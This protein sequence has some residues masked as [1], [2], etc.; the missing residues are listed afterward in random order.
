MINKQA[1]EHS[2]PSPRGGFGVGVSIFLF[3][4]I[5]VAAACSDEEEDYDPYYSWGSRNAQWFQSATDSARKDIAE[6]KALYGDEWQQHAQ[7]RVYK[8]LN[9]AQDYDTRQLT[10]SIVVRVISRGE[11]SVSPTWTDTVRISQR[12]WLMPTTY[13]MYNAQGQ[14]QD[15]LRQ[16]VFSQT[17]YGAFDSTTAA[18]VLS[19]VSL[20]TEG[21]ATALQYMVEGDDW[22]V[23]IPY[24]LAYGKE[25]RD[26][27][28]GYS[29]LQFRI[30]MAAVYPAGTPVPSWKA[31]ARR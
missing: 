26:V 9:Q 6:A 8:S 25:G 28:P 19:A 2:T 14:L 17:C 11:G 12:G 16:E 7:W 4:L 15:S 10:D 31:P 5:L 24:P 23:Y 13:R 21:F 27:I 20:F 18:P 3:L 29:T 30:H 1:S 22:L